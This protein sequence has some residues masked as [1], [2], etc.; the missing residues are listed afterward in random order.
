MKCFLTNIDIFGDLGSGEFKASYSRQFLKFFGGT[1][2]FF[3]WKL[4]M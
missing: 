4:P 3:F 2:K 1:P